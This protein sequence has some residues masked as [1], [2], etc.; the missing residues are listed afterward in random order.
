M[1]QPRR[2]FV[3]ALVAGV[4]YFVFGLAFGELAARAESH[5]MVVTWRLAAWIASAI[6]YGAHLTREIRATR[7][8]HQTAMR[9]A[10]GAA[11]GAFGLAV[12]ANLHAMW[13]PDANP[14]MNLLR[15]SLVIWPIGTFIPAYLVGLAAAAILKRL[16]I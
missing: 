12:A 5:Q 15:L 7:S 3:F 9:A 6:V 10:V 8:L 11:I 16:R 2:W 1:T 13:T 14:H 4:A